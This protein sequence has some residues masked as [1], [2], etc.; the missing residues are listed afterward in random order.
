MTKVEMSQYISRQSRTTVRVYVFIYGLNLCAP[1]FNRFV[2]HSL[3]T[4]GLDFT[5]VH[6][7]WVQ[8]VVKRKSNIGVLPFH[9][10]IVYL[11][12]GLER[13]IDFSQSQPPQTPMHTVT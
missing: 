11:T 2:H 13:R 3:F 7:S 9:G 1:H 5:V 4:F 6:W 10:L 12:A 8:R